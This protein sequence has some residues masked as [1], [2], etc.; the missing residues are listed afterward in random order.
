MARPGGNPDLKG[1]K[2]SGRKSANYERVKRLAIS[3]AWDKV[4]RNID[5]KEVEKIAL[6]L[7]LR[8]MTE[9]K[10]YSGEINVI[11]LL[12]GQSNCKEYQKEYKETPIYKDEEK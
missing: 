8:D 7:A 6:P 9:K 2:N 11:P 12:G 1:N 5:R 10:E 4:E 3:K